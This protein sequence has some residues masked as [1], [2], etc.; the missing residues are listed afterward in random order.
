MGKSK[1]ILLSAISLLLFLFVMAGTSFPSG[2]GQGQKGMPPG[3]QK[4]GDKMP[5]GFQEG[6]KRGFIGGRPPGWSQ[7][8][9]EGWR[10][11][12]PPGLQG[13]ANEEKR[14]EFTQK[15]KEAEKLLKGKAAEKKIKEEE[16][17][18]LALLFNLAARKGV[19][20]HNAL[21][22]TEDMLDHGVEKDGAERITR[23]YAYGV[24]KKA[25]Y[26]SL[27]RLVSEKL[28]AGHK[29]DDLATLIYDEIDKRPGEQKSKPKPE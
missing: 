22:L 9:K 21:K 14:T 18:Y 6:E 28:K 17:Q 8:E 10:G 3:L 23:A 19:P 29:G 1:V 11:I 20:I 16:A 24:D 26:D 12:Y 5:P 27:G 4:K 13:G 25:D 2:Q 15:R 7:G